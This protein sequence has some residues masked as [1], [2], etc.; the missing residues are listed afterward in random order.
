MARAINLPA[1]DVQTARNYLTLADVRS[2]ALSKID[3]ELLAQ[4][5]ELIAHS[6]HHV[7]QTQQGAHNPQDPIDRK[8]LERHLQQAEVHVAQGARH[9]RE[10]RERLSQLA[11]AGHDI[12]EAQTLLAQFGQLQEIHVATRDRLARELRL[13]ALQRDARSGSEAPTGAVEAKGSPRAL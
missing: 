5:R 13:D 1:P 11:R 7:K 10:Q 3:L 6:R 2:V 8:M 9:V 12:Q 4:S